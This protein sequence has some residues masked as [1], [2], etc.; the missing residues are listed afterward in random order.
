MCEKKSFS[1]SLFSFNFCRQLHT[2]HEYD[3]LTQN[4]MFF[5]GWKYGTLSAM[6]ELL[7]GVPFGA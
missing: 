2:Y 1:V 4:E 6:H 5:Q 3:S 7:K